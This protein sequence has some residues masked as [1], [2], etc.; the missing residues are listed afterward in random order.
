[1]MEPKSM[2]QWQR[3]MPAHVKAKHDAMT[4]AEAQQAADELR[5]H[6]DGIDAA[7]GVVAYAERE[8]QYYF[9][10]LAASKVA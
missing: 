10:A 2:A 4:K 9:E 7:G 3:G 8:R 1:M 5:R 6:F